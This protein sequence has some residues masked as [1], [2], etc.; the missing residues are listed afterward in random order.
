[1]TSKPK[2]TFSVERREIDERDPTLR[3][4]PD[5]GNPTT[6][7]LVQRMLNIGS[8][9][10][11]EIHI[12]A[13]GIAPRMARMMLETGNYRLFDLSSHQ[14]V[15]VNGKAI[16]SQVL[17]DGDTIRMQDG[18][19]LG[20]TMYYAN[21]VERALKNEAPGTFELNVSPFIIGRDGAA[22][23][24]LDGN[25]VSWQHAQITQ[26]GDGHTITDLKSTNGTYINDRR[27][28]PNK[29]HRLQQEDVIRIDQTLLVYRNKTLTRISGAQRLQMDAIDLEMTYR[30]G[31]LRP[32]TLNT[33]RNVT[34]SIKP[35]E[36]VAIIGGSG[37]G[38]STLLRALNGANQA[39]GGKVLVNGDDL[40]E[41]YEIF[42]PVIGYVPQSDIVQNNL[43]IRE[44]LKYGAR[45]RFPNEPEASREQRINRVL[46]DVEL[47]DYQDRLVRNLSGGQKKRVSIALELMADPRL[48]FLDEP[49]SGL[50]P[51]L[52]KSLM[53]TLR[54]LADR[55]HVVVVVTHTTLNIDMCDKLCLMARGNLVYYGPPREALGFFSVKEYPDIYNAVMQSPETLEKA[56]QSET[57]IMKPGAIAAADRPNEKI[58]PFEAAAKWAEK[59]RST[60]LYQANIAGK[61]TNPGTVAARNDNTLRNKRL[62]GARRG[63]FWQQLQVL[64]A[65]TVALARRDIRTLLVMLMVL[66]LVGLFLGYISRDAIEQD[67]GKMLVSRGDRTEL[68]LYLEEIP[69]TPIEQAQPEDAAAAQDASS[70]SGGS[71]GSRNNRDSG[72]SSNVKAIGTYAPANDAQ[73]LLFM[74]A[75]SVTLLGI[76]ASAYTIVEEKSLFMR[77]RMVN[78]RIAPYLGSKVVVYGGLAMLSCVLLL[79]T[80]WTGVVLPGQGLITWGPLEMFITLALTALAGVSIGLVLSA[81]SRQVNAV[82][83]LVL[84]VLFVQILFPGV[85]F[86]MDGALEPL[87]RIT[88]TRWALE[89]LGGTANM[90]ERNAEGSI[91]V[92]SVPVRNGRPL[93]KAP[94]AKQ[95]LPSPSAL[96]VTY[97]TTATDLLVRWA[98]LA[99]F[100]VV[101]LFIAS[102]SLNRSE[103]F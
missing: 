64:T 72:Q 83:Y 2:A 23:L 71:G 14:G 85:L 41:N 42:Q 22:N 92:E 18:T 4:V 97:P 35:Q 70:E 102:L 7:L 36:F 5:E 30:T 99:G 25:S 76:F 20:V 21:P 44:A 24:S 46:D 61:Q 51:G 62:Q 74:M 26:Q 17:R 79:A 80:V 73:R 29:P 54:K 94:T 32:K 91:V 103:S 69:L 50:D 101:F 84:A 52:D 40:Y 89:G 34:L 88:I 8:D 12:A 58:S 47:T 19:G 27:L 13:P 96:S 48:L 45:L 28:A 86:K 39:T 95:V 81:M 1:M 15:L 49:S 68:L 56:K 78:L 77:E 82:T 100:S 16:N 31:F 11:Q 6:V 53:D 93:T 67:R 33:M 9:P 75:L 37:S 63:T 57:M 98:A 55:G 59:F 87:S 10:S 43:T 90:M 38:K 60:T 3:I 66:P 65:R